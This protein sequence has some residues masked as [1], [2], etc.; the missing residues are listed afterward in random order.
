MPASKP[1][2]K[3]TF[4]ELVAKPSGGATSGV[5]IFSGDL[6]DLLPKG[7]DSSD[8]ELRKPPSPP[9]AGVKKEL[10]KPQKVIDFD[11]NLEGLDEEHGFGGSAKSVPKA[12]AVSSSQL[13]HFDI[14]FEN[15]EA[16]SSVPNSSKEK[17]S[18]S[19][20]TSVMKKDCGSDPEPDMLSSLLR[21]PS[22]PPPR[23]NS[24]SK[25]SPDL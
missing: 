12:T 10:G 17:Y 14:D 15:L 21:N 2:F 11:F 8:E 5:S 13:I 16:N 6:D 7:H 4:K 23:R 3:D 1:M 19:S 18:P 22:P 24:S 20:P 9:R 25:S